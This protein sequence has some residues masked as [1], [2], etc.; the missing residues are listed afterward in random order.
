MNTEVI[1]VERT[2]SPAAAVR[3][4]AEVLI[5][6]GVVVFPTET[7]YGVA[8]RADDSDAL[9]RLRA[10]KRRAAGVPF[11]LHVA[12]NG[13]ALR[14]A[15]N[16]SGTARRMMRKGWPGPL[17]LVLPTVDTPAG[18]GSG[19][20]GIEG[21]IVDRSIGLRCPDDYIATEILRG[22]PHPVAASSANGSGSPPP[23]TG[24]EA[25]GA[26]GGQVELLIDAGVTRYAKPSTIVCVTGRDWS[27]LRDGVYDQRMVE[28]FARLRVL[29]VCTGN[30]CRSPMAEGL[31][32][33]VLAA[34]VGCEVSALSDHGIEV[35][36][37]GTFGGGGGGISPHAAWSL[38]RRDVR[39][40]RHVSRTL[41]GGLLHRADHVFTMTAAHREA[42]LSLG[43]FAADRVELLIPDQDIADPMGGAQSDYDRCADAIEQ[44][45]RRRM[46]EVPL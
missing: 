40:P 28:E 39:L 5:G 30:T 44:A 32:K 25:L 23:H 33:Q 22:V 9:E 43:S 3:R 29:F 1:K 8:A 26:C 19:S 4:A 18:E 16:A 15:P 12:T 24:T 45:V 46:N 17:T 38:A 41:T 13:D 2:D 35:E 34:R 6:G 21:I 37:A 42:V 14:Y 11:T 27:I 36:S 7:V 31:A 20:K 10:V